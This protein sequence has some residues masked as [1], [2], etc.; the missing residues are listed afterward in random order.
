M[1]GRVVVVDSSDSGSSWGRRYTITYGLLELLQL[2]VPCI[3]IRTAATGA[4]LMIRMKGQ[5]A[6]SE[7]LIPYPRFND[8]LDFVLC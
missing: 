6:I 1:C 3:R 5:V 7:N 2:C 4:T 8:L